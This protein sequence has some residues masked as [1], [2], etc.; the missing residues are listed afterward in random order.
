MSDSKYSKL[1]KTPEYDK[2][3]AEQLAAAYNEVN[4][5][6][7]RIAQLNDLIAENPELRVFVWHTA[8]GKAIAVHDLED[9][10]LANILR[11]QV[12]RGQSINAG[13][14]GEARKRKMLIP[15]VA[16]GIDPRV[17]IEAEMIDRKTPGF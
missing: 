8:E 14:R 15:S 9:D 5:L 1:D 7:A 17:L 10:H 2:E 11:W 6:Q 16:P 13:L 12:G 3:A 4:E